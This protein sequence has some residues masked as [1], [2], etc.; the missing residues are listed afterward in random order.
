MLRFV[1]L[2]SCALAV[3]CGAEEERDEPFVCALGELSGT[4]IL[5]HTELDGDCGAI[6]DRQ[7]T[8]GD[9]GDLRPEG[10]ST[11]DVVISVDK[12]GIHQHFDC[13]L[14]AAVGLEDWV[15]LLSHEAPARIAGL[16]SLVVVPE[17][18]VSAYELVL[19]PR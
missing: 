13:P 9:E 7:V 16:G 14:A 3:G 10:C 8:F 15:V 1:R 18:C 17:T 19:T 12:C 11:E 6:A 4:W 2:L 5:R